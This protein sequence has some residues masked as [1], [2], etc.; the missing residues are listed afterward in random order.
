MDIF[1][2]ASLAPPDS[3]IAVG[4]FDGVHRGHVALLGHVKTLASGADVK[5]GLLT[6][7]PHPRALFRSD[8]PP[9]RITPA[10]LKLRRLAASGLDFTC[11]LP[12]DWD[13]AS[14]TAEAFI[15]TVLRRGLKP[16]HIVVG[17][18]F[19]FGQLRKGSAGT[20]RQAGFTVTEIAPVTNDDGTVFSSSLIRELL[21]KGEIEAANALLGY[22][23]EIEGVVFHGNKRGRELGYPTANV[24]LGDTLHPA[25]GVYATRVQIE[26]EDQWRPAATNI[27]IRPMFKLQV[28]QVEAHILDFAGDI[29][30]KKL[31][32]QPVRKLRGE[33]KF[34]SLDA[35]I[36]QIGE[37]CGQT[38]TVLTVSA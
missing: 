5:S 8:D 2:S 30:G 16:S 11:C 32:V 12:F 27:G 38:R 31:R 10:P 9:F 6:F 19:R 29:Y 13:F 21:R 28:G 20:L 36:R 1:D 23:W 34:D 3:V 15:E 26:G 25:Y 17:Q 33:A 22:P 7:E 18:D 24:P 14:Q 35:L 4:N 37:D